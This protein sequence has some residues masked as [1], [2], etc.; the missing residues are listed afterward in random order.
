MSTMI[1]H[2][3]LRSKLHP[4]G[5]LPGLVRASVGVGGDATDIANSLEEIEKHQRDISPSAKCVSTKRRSDETP[6]LAK[7]LFGSLAEAKVLT[8][9]IAMHLDQEWRERLFAQLDDLL[10]LDDW[11]EDDEPILGASYE[12]FLRMIIYQAP[13]RRP[14]LGVSYRGNLVAAW[15]SGTDQLTLEFFP[16]DRIRWVLSCEIDGEI[17][18]AAGESAVRHF[19]RVLDPYGPDRWFSD[20]SN[21]DTT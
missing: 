15:T 14:G 6:T 18:R 3:N 17:E 5:V 11:H 16:E 9:K 21:K 13:A 10:E 2:T 19:P 8:S 12:T 1:P 4:R 20:G 7:K